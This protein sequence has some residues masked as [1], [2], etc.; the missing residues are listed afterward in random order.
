MM[1]NSHLYGHASFRWQVHFCHQFML[2]QQQNFG[3]QKH[4]WSIL[5]YC[6][7]MHTV[8]CAQDAR[9]RFMI[10]S[11]VEWVR[12]VFLKLF[13]SHQNMH[14][15]SLVFLISLEWSVCVCVSRQTLA[16]LKL[17]LRHDCRSD[18]KIFTQRE[19]ARERGDFF[20]EMDRFRLFSIERL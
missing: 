5:F 4:K 15:Q 3:H 20:E 8:V 12:F 2:Q 7:C 16:H 9:Q 10:R 14:A 11:G 17:Y 13:N 6:N 1:S 19:S 18:F